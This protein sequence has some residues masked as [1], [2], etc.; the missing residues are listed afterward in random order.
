MSHYYQ[1]DASLQSKKRSLDL[2]LND[3]KLTFISDTGVFSNNQIDYGS[4]T[5]L[6]TLLKEQKVVSLLDVGCG[7]GI[8]GIT[9]RYFGLCQEADLIDINE[10]AVMLSNENINNYHLDNISCF[11]SNGFEKITKKYDYIVINPPIRAGKEII[12]KM[13]DDSLNH[14]NDNGNLYIVIKKDLGGP[15]AIKHLKELFKNVEII[16]K[17]RGYWIIKSSN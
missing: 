6:K 8:L 12:Y 7:Y 11:V 4:Y 3:Q 15:S 2:Y 13:F 14:L 16:N 17:D 10:K 5:F 1:N 9:L